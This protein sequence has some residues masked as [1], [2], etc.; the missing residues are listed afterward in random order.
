MQTALNLYTSQPRVSTHGTLDMA[1]I[2]VS[3]PLL[4]SPASAQV[5]INGIVGSQNN[6]TI[7]CSPAESELRRIVTGSTP[8]KRTKFFSKLLRRTPLW[9]VFSLNTPVVELLDSE[10]KK[11]KEKRIAGRNLI[12]YVT[13]ISD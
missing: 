13:S 12:V 10:T 2:S 8:T 1:R 9:R 6:T 5:C 11:A 3:T 4:S 7:S